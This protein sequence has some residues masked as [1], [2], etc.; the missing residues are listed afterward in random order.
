MKGIPIKFRGKTYRGDYVTFFLGSCIE[1]LSG[2][3]SVDE[4]EHT[5]IA[6]SICQLVGYDA[7]GNEI[8]EGDMLTD[9]YGDKFKAK[10]F[11][12]PTIEILR[13]VDSDE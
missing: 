4:G 7:D 8:Y 1:K 11:V 5:V 12:D 6:D 2:D 10:L 13:K 9:N 3:Y